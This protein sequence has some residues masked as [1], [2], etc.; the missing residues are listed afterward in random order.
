[1]AKCASLQKSWTQLQSLRFPSHLLAHSRRKM[2]KRA[3]STW[4]YI[5][6]VKS[7]LHSAQRKYFLEKFRPFV[8]SPIVFFSYPVELQS[9]LRVLW[10]VF[11]QPLRFL[12]PLQLSIPETACL[13]DLSLLIFLRYSLTKT[14]LKFLKMFFDIVFILKNFILTFHWYKILSTVLL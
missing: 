9:L 3:N 11:L 2:G 12:F 14:A 1:M 7:A 13:Y 6:E 8:F 4:I 10:S 5:F